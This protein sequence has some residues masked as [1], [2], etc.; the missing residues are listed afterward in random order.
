[1]QKKKIFYT[2]N[3]KWL[4]INLQILCF[5]L[6]LSMKNNQANL[7]GSSWSQL[8]THDHLNTVHGRRFLSE[9]NQKDLE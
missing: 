8:K 7:L 2:S 4:K 5:S 9:K 1:M 6:I 3:F